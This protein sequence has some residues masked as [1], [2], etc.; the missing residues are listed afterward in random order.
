MS[1]YTLHVWQSDSQLILQWGVQIVQSNYFLLLFIVTKNLSLM[2]YWRKIF[3]LIELN[4]WCIKSMQWTSKSVYTL[5]ILRWHSSANFS[6]LCEKSIL[7]IPHFHA[8]TDDHFFMKINDKSAN[9]K[10]LIVTMHMHTHMVDTSISVISFNAILIY[11]LLGCCNA[12]IYLT[13]FRTCSWINR[14][15]IGVKIE[16]WLKGLK[17]NV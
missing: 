4:T 14:S 3:V 16:L 11:F 15:L 7:I 12:K 5:L 6:Q 10:K 1:F 17:I 8:S 2:I 13:F 9:R